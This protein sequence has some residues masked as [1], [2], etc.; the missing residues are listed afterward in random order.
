MTVRNKI[1]VTFFVE[2]GCKQEEGEVS[3]SWVPINFSI[4]S[5]IF[6]DLIQEAIDQWIVDNIILDN[7][8][9]EVI[10]AHQSD[11]D[12]G[13]ALLGEWFEPI[14]TESQGM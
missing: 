13:G 1:K 9:Y 3:V 6:I 14:Y 5:P 4:Y 11:R 12:G 8:E 7:T 10:F 2:D